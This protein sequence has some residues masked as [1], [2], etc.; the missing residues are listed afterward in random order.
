MDEAL[1]QGETY[2]PVAACSKD[3]AE[4]ASGELELQRFEWF[5]EPGSPEGMGIRSSGTVRHAQ[6]LNT[7]RVSDLVH[8]AMRIPDHE[9]W[10]SLLMAAQAKV[11]SYKGSHK[12]TVCN[13]TCRSRYSSVKI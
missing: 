12:H 8:Q 7:A 9:S 10:L 4:F 11:P 13:L 1:Q 5:Q 3:A 2:T 6:M